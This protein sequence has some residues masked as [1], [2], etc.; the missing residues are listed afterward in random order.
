MTNAASPSPSHRPTPRRRP[1]RLAVSDIELRLLR[2][3]AEIVRCNG[4][5]AAETALGMSQATISTHMRHLEERVGLRLC[6]RG[7]GGFLLTEEGRR[8]HQA[9]LELF[10]SI[11][12]FEGRL[13]DIAGDMAGRLAFGTVDAMAGNTGLKLH[14]AFATF[15]RAAPRVELEIE[16]AAPQAL[17]Q[18]LASGRYQLAVL[19][20][21]D[22]AALEAGED[23][24]TERQNLYCGRRH[25]LF[26]LP[27]AALT[28]ELLAAQDFAGRSY[29]RS[30][31]ICG[32]AFRWAATTAH[33]EGTLL[34]LLSGG[35]IGFLPDHY[36]A[37][38]GAGLRALAPDRLSFTDHFRLV[39]GREQPTRAARLLAEAI[40][41]AAAH[42]RAIP[43]V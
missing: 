27:D 33:M 4:F 30:P 35:Y 29:M 3:F 22:G 1:G 23:I 12:R 38:A 39:H 26:D 7:R 34:L 15:H 19:P 6:E 24:F 20:A 28:A 41:Q 13:G 18:G 36:A 25:P 43:A 14:E 9:T 17:A 21:Q 31:V 32:V 8:V 5:T 11:E 37:S 40:R 2:V 16:I 10:G 42:P